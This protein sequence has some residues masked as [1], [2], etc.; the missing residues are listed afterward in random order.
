M[1]SKE[2]CFELHW[3]CGTNKEIASRKKTWFY[4][5]TGAYIEVNTSSLMN[6]IWNWLRCP[7]FFLEEKGICRAQWLVLNFLLTGINFEESA[8]TRRELNQIPISKAL[9]RLCSEWSLADL[10]CD[11]LGGW[12]LCLVGEWFTC[13]INDWL[14]GWLTNWLTGWLI[15]LLTWLSSILLNECMPDYLTDWLR[16]VVTDWLAD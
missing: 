6:M 2:G 11:W 4:S 16:Y 14:T 1:N 3:V 9:I 13:W 5:G 7:Y 8:P 10:V 12:M 15:K